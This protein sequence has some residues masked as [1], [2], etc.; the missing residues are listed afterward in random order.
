MGHWEDFFWEVAEEVNQL[1][2][3]KEFDKLLH[4]IRNDEKYRYTELKDRWSIALMK[5]KEQNNK[6]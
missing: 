2:L 5:L 3:R 4:Q 6:T 1:G